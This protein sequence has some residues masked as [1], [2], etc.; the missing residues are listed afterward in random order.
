MFGY[1][2]NLLLALNYMRGKVLIG[3]RVNLPDIETIQLIVIPDSRFAIQAIRDHAAR[4]MP[5]A[6]CPVQHYHAPVC[7]SIMDTL[8]EA[9]RTDSGARD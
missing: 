6:P 9:N 5:H 2:I 3:L 4:T 1:Q 8:T 7:A